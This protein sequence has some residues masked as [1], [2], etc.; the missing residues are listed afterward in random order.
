MDKNIKERWLAALRGG[1]Y[2][3]GRNQLNTGSGFCCLGVLTDLFIKE[4]QA[5]G[6]DYSWK[7]CEQGGLFVSGQAPLG[8]AEHRNITPGAVVRWAGLDNTDG[9]KMLPL[10]AKMNDNGASFSEL[11][12]FIEE[13]L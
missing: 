5:K 6:L 1:E 11:A 13:K 3:Q 10:L 9:D 7:E 12:N 2:P 8:Y 4:Q